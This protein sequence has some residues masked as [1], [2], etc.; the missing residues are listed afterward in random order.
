MSNVPETNET[1]AP[2]E[3]NA[4]TGPD[5]DNTTS[6]NGQPQKKDGDNW[7]EAY[8]QLEKK[9]GEQGKELGEYRSF[10]QGIEPLLN[11]LDSNPELVQGI[12][13]GKIT[14]E[15]VKSAL[16]G[17]L[18]VSEA[19]QASKATAEVKEDLKK[20]NKDIKQLSEEDVAKLVEKKLQES[21]KGIERKNAEKDFQARTEAFIEKTEDFEKYA[22]E[23]DKWLDKHDVTDIEVAYYAVK[24]QLSEREAQ[25]AAE[26]AAAEKA[27]E[28]LSN[29]SGGGQGPTHIDEGSPIVDKLI[30]RHSNPNNL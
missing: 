30:A 12:L 25:K 9:L 27:K 18:S 16:E 3:E 8:K 1:N 26:E 2:Q 17:D 21:L 15:F 13:D 22:E 20:Q 6:E 23:I 19:E 10:L 28:V 14:E 24:G 7:E 5:A 4:G 11:K 29:A